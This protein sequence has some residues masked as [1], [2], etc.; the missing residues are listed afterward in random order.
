MLGV[1]IQVFALADMVFNFIF[2]PFWFICL[3][4]H[5]FVINLF[6]HT[7]V[8]IHPCFCLSIHVTINLL[9]FVHSPDVTFSKSHSY[10]Y[11]AIIPNYALGSWLL[12][13]RY[14][15]TKGWHGNNSHQSNQTMTR[16]YLYYSSAESYAY[17]STIWTMS[18]S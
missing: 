16:L 2:A 15:C 6:F 7:F 9:S 11:Q 17:K 12:K 14:T 3:L 4:V 5:L 10:N 18:C 8:N 13:Y 1:L